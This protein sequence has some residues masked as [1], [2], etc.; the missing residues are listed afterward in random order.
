MS[1]I[2]IFGLGRMG[3]AL[4]SALIGGSHRVSVWN[5]T[6]S[7]AQPLVNLGATAA[8]S[9]DA[10]IEASPILLVCVDNYHVTRS[11]FE[12][13]SIARKL[14]GR[15]VIQLSTGTPKEA[16]ESEMWF[17]ALGAK[18]LDGA[19]LCGPEEIATPNSTVLYAGH[20]EV[21]SRC[22]KLLRSFGQDCRF[23]GEKIGAASA[24]DLAWLSHHYGMFAG[25][26]HGAIL[27]ESEGVD[28][29]LYSNTFAEKDDARW[30][31]GIIKSDAFKNPT[32]TLKV[33]NSALRRI[34][35]QASDMGIKCEV[36]D[37]VGNILNRAEAAGYGEE[38]IAAMVK[39]LRGNENK[40]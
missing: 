36:P 27:C 19:I 1:D 38:H 5:R 11:I 30:I 4:A 7:K 16:R 12:A 33:W 2:S 14:S 20:S 18:Y 39:V 21:F 40:N 24:L 25:L 15:I 6:P 26:A 10:A 29:D 13:D 37:F 22:N 3:S 35:T 28:L 17:T 9:V 34:R 32:A 8:P 31:L 23:V